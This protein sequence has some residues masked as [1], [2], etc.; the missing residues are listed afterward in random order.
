M[1]P[2][3]RQQ[4]NHDAEQQHSH[5][6]PYRIDQQRTAIANRHRRGG[7]FHL[8]SSSGGRF[9]PRV[10]RRDRAYC[11]SST[12]AASRPWLKWI[13]TFSPTLVSSG[14]RSTSPSS[15]C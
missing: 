9:S 15:R 1:P 10:P 7:F 12:R 3:L 4:D 6:V 8:T 5:A 2:V 11:V 13:L 14:E